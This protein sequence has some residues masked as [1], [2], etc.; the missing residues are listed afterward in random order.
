MAGEGR[1]GDARA[2]GANSNAGVGTPKPVLP[3]S[4][5][6]AYIN[7]TGVVEAPVCGKVTGSIDEGCSKQSIQKDWH[8]SVH[9]SGN[10]H[11][12]QI[13]CFN[14]EQCP[15]GWASKKISGASSANQTAGLVQD[16]Q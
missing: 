14:N 13:A 1:V 6:P 3:C 2:V 16:A 12:V 10:A 8:E 5:C 9:V 11:I 7:L 4:A 15:L